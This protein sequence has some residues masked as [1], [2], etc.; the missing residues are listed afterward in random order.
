MDFL[1]LI[2]WTTT[3]EGMGKGRKKKKK[4]KR[5]YRTS[6]KTINVFL[7]S[8]L[9]ES[10]PSLRI[11][12]RLTS[13][14]GGSLPA[15]GAAQILICSHSCMSCL[16]GP[17]LSELVHFLLWELSMDFYIFHR[18]RV[19]LVDRV[20]LFCNLYNWWEFWVF[21]LSHTAPE[22]QLWFYF[23]LYMLVCSWGCP[24]GLGFAPVRASYGGGAAA[25]VA[26]VLTAPGTQG[27]WR[28]GQQEI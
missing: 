11:T 12:V 24:G 20:D 27:R 6:Q 14:G 9:W 5:I 7:E 21:F 18:H 4:S 28:L 2:K 16:Q 17:Q 15:V 8:L 22:F 13:L 25:W 1:V 3:T 26:G 10:F 19:C 23:H